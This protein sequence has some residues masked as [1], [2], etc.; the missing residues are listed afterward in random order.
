MAFL[1]FSSVVIGEVEYLM[2]YTVAVPTSPS[3]P[4][5]VQVNVRELVVAWL[6]DKSIAALGGVTS[7]EGS[8]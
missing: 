3:S 8:G 5:A 7:G 6:A 4:G 1:Q 2:S